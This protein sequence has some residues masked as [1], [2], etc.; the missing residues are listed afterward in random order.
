ME[1]A[2]GSSETV[3]KQLTSTM[4]RLIRQVLEWHD[5]QNKEM[6]KMKPISLNF[7]SMI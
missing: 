1:L 7:F 3:Q 2:Q 4:F 6:K 5:I